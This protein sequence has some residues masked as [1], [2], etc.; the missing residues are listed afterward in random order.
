MK[1]TKY[2]GEEK[3]TNT[4]KQTNPSVPSITPLFNLLALLNKLNPK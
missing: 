4:K 3:S 1:L 2:N